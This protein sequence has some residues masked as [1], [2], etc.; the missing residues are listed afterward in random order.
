MNDKSDTQVDSPNKAIHEAATLSVI[1]DVHFVL[2]FH[3]ELMVD[4]QG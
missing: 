3:V 1:R 4:S 2:G